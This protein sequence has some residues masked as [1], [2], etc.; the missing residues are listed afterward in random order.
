[1]VSAKVVEQTYGGLESLRLIRCP[2]CTNRGYSV[3]LMPKGMGAGVGL[4]SGVAA[5]VVVLQWT[6]GSKSRCADRSY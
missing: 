5:T 6:V 3:L 2:W 1:M 4:L